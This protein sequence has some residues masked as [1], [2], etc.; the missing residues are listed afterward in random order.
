[1]LVS[2]ETLGTVTDRHM[3]DMTWLWWLLLFDKRQAG[4]FFLRLGI[5]WFMGL[6]H[7]LP[8]FSSH[9]VAHEGHAF[10]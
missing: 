8:A 2:L 10:G 4:G 3:T 7:H 9:C 1:M 5:K 6:W